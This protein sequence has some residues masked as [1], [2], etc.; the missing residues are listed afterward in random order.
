[1]LY[2]PTTFHGRHVGVGD[3]RLKCAGGGRVTS[4]G[5]VLTMREEY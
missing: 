2:S 5:T 1:M 4:A 3:T